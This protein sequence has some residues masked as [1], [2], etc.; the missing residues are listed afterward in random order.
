MDKA[1]T[2][3]DNEHMV[4]KGITSE[5]LELGQL[6]DQ[7]NPEM[8]LIDALISRRSVRKYQDR[9][10]PRSLIEKL[11]RLSTHA[12]SAC[13]RRA[14]RF[15]LIEERDRLD[16][17][18]QNGGA[19]FLKS[20]NQAVLV[21]YL[22][23]TENRPWR[24]VEQSASAAIM[25]FQTLAHIHGIGS[26]WVCHLPPKREVRKY[27]GIPSG[28]T[29]IALVTFGYYRQNLRMKKRS[30]EGEDILCIN[31]WNF[32]DRS[33]TTDSFKA[34]VKGTLRRMY[35]GIP[36]RGWLRRF[37]VPFEKTF[38]NEVNSDES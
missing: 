24:D 17:L 28:Y 26:C 5:T 29:P 13:N 35:Y 3:P 34:I 18:Y 16:W 21:C 12:P 1:A 20:S 22:E 33:T 11:L 19:A 6:S 2:I 8:G 10:V 23:R 7:P 4:W 30:V 15:I 27:F 31:R 32:E 37:T 36:R 9:L 25:L 14:W 38:H